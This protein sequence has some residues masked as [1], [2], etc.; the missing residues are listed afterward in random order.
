MTEKRENKHYD[1]DLVIVGAGISGLYTLYKLSKLYPKLKIILL[2]ANERYGG[3]IYTYKE[4]IDEKEYIMDLGAGRLGYD[5]KLIVGLIEE[6]GLS[7]KIINI[8]NAKTYIEVQNSRIED[9]TKMKAQIMEK[10]YKFLNSSSKLGK[11]FLQKLYF[12]ELLTKFCG[13]KFSHK[14]E[15]IFEYSADLNKLNAY[16]A[17]N[18]FKYDYN[19]AK[20]F[21]LNGGI[22][23]IIERLL[24]AI[25]G[26]PGYKSRNIKIS[27]LSNVENISYKNN[28]FHIK[29]NKIRNISIKSSRTNNISSNYVICALPKDSLEK[30][31]ICKPI[32]RDLSKINN[33]NLLRIFEVYN[34]ENG[35]M[36]FQNIQK[37]V[38][39]SNL[40][41]VIPISPDNGLIMSSYSDCNN[42]NFWKSL[43]S[44]KGINVVKEKLNAALNQLFSIYNIVVPQSKYIKMYYWEAGVAY[45]KKNVDS[46]YL[47]EK[48]LNPFPKFYIIGENY[49]K[50]QA[51]AEGAL[52]TAES[53]IEK[54]DFKYQRKTRKTRKT[55]TTIYIKKELKELK[56]GSSF[57]LEEVEKHN[58]INDAWIIIKGKVYDVTSWI[59]KHPGGPIILQGIGKD[60][61]SFFKNYGHPKYVEKTILP[62]YYIGKL[63]YL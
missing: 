3:R 58:T 41:F 20:Y 59:P 49:S 34:K 42:A 47:S 4:V 26:N 12:N 5:H 25:K 36:W 7:N 55:L 50:Y 16:N 11:N 33:I 48:L 2:E 32:L 13:A 28:R 38:T 6:L 52:M 63:V 23:Q 30:F 57:T 37:T 43:L 10:L 27:N 60:A 56:G 39:N 29:I 24:K 46:D 22:G 21:T 8:E 35:S 40:Q 61:T 17:I 54:L 19:D 45:W 18:Y 62:K 31:D 51:W 9:K 53:C 1:Y 14:L 44:K 15:S